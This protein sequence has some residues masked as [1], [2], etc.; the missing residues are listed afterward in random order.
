MSCDAD[1]LDHWFSVEGDLQ[2]MNDSVDVVFDKGTLDALLSGFSAERG[3]C[4]NPNASLYAAEVL[5]I[6][7]KPSG[8]SGGGIFVLVSINSKEVVAPYCYVAGAERSDDYGL[9]LIHQS[10]LAY[11]VKLESGER[12]KSLHSYGTHYSVFV[13][14]VV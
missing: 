10:A 6:L 2:V 11:D 14:Q 13:F 1:K 9:A 12:A 8:D 7:R 5:N 3:D 4:G